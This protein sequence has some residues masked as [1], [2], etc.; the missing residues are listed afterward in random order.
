RRKCRVVHAAHVRVILD[1]YFIVEYLDE[2]GGNR[3][4]P[5][6][7]PRRWQVKS[8]HSLINGMLDSMLLWRDERVV[9]QR[10]WQAWPADHWTRVGIG[11]SRF[12]NRPDVLPG[13]FD[14]AQ[15]GLA[16]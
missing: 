6:Y 4:I 7:G 8:D 14:I 11:R 3:L 2:L 15:I 12:E 13:P 5:A 10:P 1:S 16:C 9:P